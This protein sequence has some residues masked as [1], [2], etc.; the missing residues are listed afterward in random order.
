LDILGSVAAWRTLLSLLIVFLTGGSL[1]FEK[2]LVGLWPVWTEIWRGRLS[3]KEE[4]FD[5]KETFPSS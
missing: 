2:M 3:N 1:G 4:L 5:E